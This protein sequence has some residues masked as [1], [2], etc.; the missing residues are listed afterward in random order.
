[1]ARGH[2]LS[3]RR[4]YITLDDI[5]LIIKVVLSTASIE[6]ATIFDLLLAYKGTMTTAQ[7]ADS[8]NISHPT[9]LRTMTELKALGL[10][11]MVNGD[12]NTPAQI[13][14]DP[15]F[16]WVFEKE[17]V[18]LRNGFVPSDNGEYVKKERKEK[19]PLSSQKNE[20]DF[21]VA[22]GDEE[23]GGESDGAEAHKEKS[24]LT[25]DNL[26]SSDQQHKE[27]ISSITDDKLS[28]PNNNNGEDVNEYSSEGLEAKKLEIKFV[29]DYEAG[30]TIFWRF[31]EQLS[32]DNV[33]GLVHYDKLQDRLISTGK[34]YAG[35]AVL[36]IEYM[37]K[38]GEI[39]ETEIYHVYRRKI[40]ASPELKHNKK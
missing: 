15:Q 33:E 14:L 29:P 10:V 36:M 26:I 22:R 28:L 31:F 38:N 25:H 39:E 34:F 13:T 24:P 20:N 2:A 27:K 5:P 19:Y 21:E 40:G 11:E 16:S 17:F 23:D 7:I 4:N 35:D 3:G 32:K 6:R 37:E 1:L 12:P 30:K 18:E 8:L 9:A